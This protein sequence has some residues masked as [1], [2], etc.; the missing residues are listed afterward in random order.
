M[1][2]LANKVDESGAVVPFLSFYIFIFLYC[3]FIAF[4]GITLLKIIQL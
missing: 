3:P 2:I 4:I 1:F